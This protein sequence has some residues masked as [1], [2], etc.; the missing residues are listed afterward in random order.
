MRRFEG[1]ER[2]GISMTTQFV[3]SAPQ[4]K[5]VFFFLLLTF[6]CSLVVQAAPPNKKIIFT[7]DLD[8]DKYA[9]LRILRDP[10]ARDSVLAIVVS[11]G[12]TQLKAASVRQAIAGYG[13]NIPVYA[14]TSVNMAGD[15]VTAFAAANELE[16]Y[17]LVRTSDIAGYAGQMGVNGDAAQQVSKILKAVPTGQKIDIVDLCN[18]VDLVKA[19]NLDKGAAIAALGD[20]SAMGLYKVLPDGTV[21]TPYNGRGA[22]KAV[23]DLL[24]LRGQGFFR[25]FN[26]IP[27]DT[28][29]Q[30]SSLPG[31]YIPL[32]GE[33]GEIRTALNQVMQGDPVLSLIQHS[34]KEYGLAWYHAAMKDVGVGLGSESDRWIPSSFPDP[35]AAT[36]YYIADSLVAEMSLATDE[37]LAQMDFRDTH[38][39]AKTTGVVANPINFNLT[40]GSTHVND[41]HSIDGMGLLR[42]QLALASD[43]NR[44]PPTEDFGKSTYT[45]PA[46]LA[47]GLGV[48]INT[49]AASDHGLVIIFKNSPDDYFGL[50]RILSTEKGRSALAHGGIIAEGF[51]SDEVAKALRN[52]LGDLGIEYIPVAAGMKYKEG[53]IESITAPNFKLELAFYNENHQGVR[54]FKDL[55]EA[56]DRFRL[57]AEQIMK[58]AAASAQSRGSKVDY[59]V[60]GEGVDLFR[61]M[62]TNADIK[63]H[64]G[65]VST[66]GGGRYGKPKAEGDPAP[67]IPSRN[68]LAHPEE[69]LGGINA[70]G[71]KKDS[72]IVFSSDEFGGAFISSKD[73]KIGNGQVA[74]NALSLG[75]ND[76]AAV[77]AI[78]EH[79]KNW[80]R[81][82]AWIMAKG[83]GVTD[84]FNPDT[85]VDLM[86]ISPLGLHMAEA[87]ITGEFEQGRSSLRVETVSLGDKIGEP[88][89][90]GGNV[91]WPRS[92]GAIRVV[93]LAAQFSGGVEEVV[94][95]QLAQRHHDAVRTGSIFS[96]D[97]A[98]S[99]D[100]LLRHASGGAQSGPS[101]K[102]PCKNVTQAAS[103]Y[104]PEAGS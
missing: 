25:R 21:A 19:I 26:H 56:P 37:Q 70:L 73:G 41:L 35:R 14:G 22:S 44:L 93:P 103:G 34:T 43:P 99:F 8:D 7:D 54:A 17:P 75:S 13:L 16:G 72:T 63:E 68:W 28:V 24:D 65:F 81:N 51:Q 79:W 88:K 57:S 46:G 49:Q 100:D 3:F 48:R 11:T 18:P 40:G 97:S 62:G 6:F 61:A 47:T 90:N 42:K 69:V 87:W 64:L 96:A 91:L 102:G 74:F 53:E 80:S 38:L 50:L 95:Q 10:E 5:T 27:T 86:N 67:W 15:P 82:F 30:R 9:L 60:Y 36:G 52:V 29:Q 2:H 20:F 58:K 94:M 39:S 4:R 89:I 78:N 23:T 98:N 45:V 12:N 104:E 92:D 101:G 76:S 83:K 84:S 77:R 31:G 85:P 66:M 55:P 32:T 59:I 33:G 1:Q 71:E